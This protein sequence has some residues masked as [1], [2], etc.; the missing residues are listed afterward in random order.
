MQFFRARVQSLMC[1]LHTSRVGYT[2]NS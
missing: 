2:K 1:D